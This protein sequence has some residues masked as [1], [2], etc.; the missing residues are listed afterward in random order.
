MTK[1]ATLFLILLPGLAAAATLREALDAAVTRAPQA[2]GLE[3]GR[4]EAA[5]HRYA[6]DR[7]FPGM[8]ALGLGQRE[9]EGGKREFELE[10]STPLWLPGQRQAS[11]A[12]ADAR[13]EENTAAYAARRW[14]LAGEL[15]NL[16]A[17]ARA[18]KAEVDLARARLE[19]DRQ[20]ADEVARRVA[21]GDLARVDSLLARGEMLASESALLEADSRLTRALR[22]YRVLTGLAALPGDAAE[23]LAAQPAGLA[24]EVMQQHP[25]LDS[26]RRNVELARAG[27]ELTR[28][29]R[30]DAPELGVQVQTARDVSGADYQNSVRF[31]LRIPFSGEARNRPLLAAANG[32][33]IR[34]EAELAQATA[35]LENELQTAQAEL[36]NA[37]RGE[38]LARARR[39]GATERLRLM[40]R[41]FDLGELSLAQLLL[42]RGQAN[43][44]EAATM[45]AGLSLAASRA[46]L[47]QAR[48]VLP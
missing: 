39:Q 44:A 6:A 30:R 21:A 43:E 20:L 4:E 31:G 19:N 17:A 25:A 35:E 42:A 3:A 13:I 37:E 9:G 26:A 11:L 16:V 10:L 28:R 45:R 5:A 8:P 48:G 40:R 15:R 24:H 22:D 41:G 12:L 2:R 47:N 23:A 7:L 33:L 18:A 1:Y 36:T 27:L 46:R 38:E 29:T 34:A 14:A 32:D